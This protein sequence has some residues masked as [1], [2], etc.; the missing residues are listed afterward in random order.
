MLFFT[1][2]VFTSKLLI[3]GNNRGCSYHFVTFNCWVVNIGKLLMHGLGGEFKLI[4]GN[5]TRSCWWN[6]GGK[7][8]D[9]R[10][11]SSRLIPL[12]VAAACRSNIP[13]M[14]I[15]TPVCGHPS[16]GWHAE[17]GS[18]KPTPLLINGHLQTHSQPT[19][20]MGWKRGDAGEGRVPQGEGR[21]R[22]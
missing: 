14:E 4:G 20:L 3:T 13:M 8:W 16:E 11:S 1:V 9:R 18:S 19:N 22:T 6:W 2:P 12:S 5:Q 15:N 17:V 7:G 21:F 10:S